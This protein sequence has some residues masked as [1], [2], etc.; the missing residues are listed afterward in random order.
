M[1]LCDLTIGDDD[2]ESLF[3]KAHKDTRCAPD[4]YGQT[5]VPSEVMAYPDTTDYPN[6]YVFNGWYTIHPDWNFHLYNSEPFFTPYPPAFLANTAIILYQAIKDDPYKYEN[7][8]NPS[9]GSV[10]YDIGSS[11]SIYWHWLSNPLACDTGRKYNETTV[12]HYGFSYTQ[13]YMRNPGTGVALYCNSYYD[14]NTWNMWGAGNVWWQADSFWYTTERERWEMLQRVAPISQ[15]GQ[16][17][18][19][20]QTV[21]YTTCNCDGPIL[22]PCNCTETGYA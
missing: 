11:A 15:Y 6:D 8:Y 19:Y 1:N 12:S 4:G 18:C 16:G 5:C 3:T 14:M 17:V 22:H 13:N 21:D 10:S 20:K 7:I 9:I 2:D